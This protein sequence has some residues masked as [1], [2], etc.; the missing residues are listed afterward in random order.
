MPGIRFR[1]WGFAGVA[2][3]LG[4]LGFGALLATSAGAAPVGPVAATPALYTPQLVSDGS[5]DQVRQM[6]QCGTTMY[7]VGKFTQIGRLGTTYPRANAFSFSAKAPF[8]VTA[9]IPT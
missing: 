4:V 7:A 6:V 5:V 8:Q 1:R 3:A 9:W 2:S